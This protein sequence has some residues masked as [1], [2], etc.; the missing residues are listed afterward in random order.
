MEIKKND[1]IDLEIGNCT[2]DGSGVGRY[3]SLAVFVPHTARGDKIKAHILKVKK[4]CAFAKIE[5]IL[6]PSPDRTECPCPVYLK[7]GGCSFGHIKYETETAI[8]ENHVRECFRRIAGTEPETEPVIAAEKIYRYRNKAQFPVEINGEEIK[9]GFYASHSHRVI[10]CPGCL[11][12]PEEFEGII[13]IIRG[14][15]LKFS[16]TSYDETSGLGLLR[17]IYLRKGTK[18]GEIMVCL[19]INGD[20]FPGEEDLC[21]RLSEKFPEIKSIVININKDKT[22]VILGKKC[23]TIYGDGYISD[24][25]CSLKFRI[26]PLSFYQVNRDQAEKLYEKAAEYAGLTG[27]ETLLDLYCGT[28]TIGLTMAHR[29][30]K[31][32]GVEI[33]G[34]AVKDA[35]LNAKENGIK[36]ARFICADAAEAARTLKDEGISPDVIILDPPRKGCSAE[37]INTVS[38]MAPDRI[39]YVSCDPATLARDCKIFAGL[40]YRA[41]KA[42]PADLFPRTGHVETVCLLY[43]QKKDFISMPYE[44]K[45]AEYLKRI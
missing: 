45:D 2:L 37:L 20:S 11:L 35:E 7:C 36:N 21:A 17:H 4:N 8:K 43:H 9:T 6:T 19:V 23:R 22:N 38:Q 26:S 13:N 28:G 14:H 30:K 25:L 10:D 16:I 44:P 41:V 31:L 24:Y 1:I 15:I 34:Q 42:A 32:I 18:S 3:D 29:V 5:E 33:I 39:V 27:N 12:Q 40:G